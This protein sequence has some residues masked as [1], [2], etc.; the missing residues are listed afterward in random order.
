MTPTIVNPE[1]GVTVLGPSRGHTVEVVSETLEKV[2]VKVRPSFRPGMPYDLATYP[3]NW[4][5]MV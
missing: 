1:T 2:T 5:V 3:P 4:L